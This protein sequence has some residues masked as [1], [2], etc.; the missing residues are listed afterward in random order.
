MMKLMN[1]VPGGTLLIP[2]MLS[3]LVY[4]FFP[5]IYDIGGVTRALLSGDSLTLS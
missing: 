2:M 3:S 4:T 5:H 1:K